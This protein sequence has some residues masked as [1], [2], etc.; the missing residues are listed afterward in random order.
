MA[1]PTTRSCRPTWCRTSCSLGRPGRRIGSPSEVCDRFLARLRESV[2]ADQAGHRGV[3]PGV[4][5]RFV[6]G[7]KDPCHAPGLLSLLPFSVFL[8]MNNTTANETAESD[9]AT[10]RRGAETLGEPADP[11]A[12]RCRAGLARRHHHPRL[13]SQS[14]AAFVNRSSRTPW[15]SP[16]RASGSC[17]RPASCTSGS[18]HWWTNI[19]IRSVTFDQDNPYG[20]HASC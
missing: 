19:D 10:E 5:G 11:A 12:E 7:R 1:E 3:V 18:I 2:Q 16:A 4:R 13:G 15:S 6:A 9:R 20:H 17:N 8:F 14:G